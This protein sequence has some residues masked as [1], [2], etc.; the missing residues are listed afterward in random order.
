MRHLRVVGEQR[1]E[2]LLR[3]AVEPA[4]VHNVPAAD[5]LPREEKHPGTQK[6]T[7]TLAREATEATTIEVADRHPPVILVVTIVGRLLPV[8]LTSAR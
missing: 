6:P 1:A 5:Q 3:H 7:V 4:A 2:H 8:P